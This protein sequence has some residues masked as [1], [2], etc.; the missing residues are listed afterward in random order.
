MFEWRLLVLWLVSFS[1]IVMFLIIICLANINRL[2]EE[3][4]MVILGRNFYRSAEDDM[5]EMEI[6]ED[7]IKRHNLEKRTERLYIGKTIIRI[8][9]RLVFENDV[10][11][12]RR[13]GF[14]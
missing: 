1:L 7:Y 9:V 5:R 8:N 13:Y 11:M 6:I 3:E 2:R 14:V 10:D 4:V 12:F